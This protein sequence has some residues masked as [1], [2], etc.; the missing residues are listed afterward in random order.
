M[1]SE[2]TKKES[3]PGITP[4]TIDQ[5]EAL[6]GFIPLCEMVARKEM[7]NVAS[8]SADFK[9]FVNIGLIKVN[10]LLREAKEKGK[11]YN[12]SY[13]IQGISWEIKN[14]NR[15]EAHQRGE[16]RSTTYKQEYIDNG[17]TLAEIREA[18]L[19]TVVSLDDNVFEIA[20]EKSFN[21]AENVEANRHF[22]FCP[23][24]FRQSIVLHKSMATISTLVFLLTT[25]STNTALTDN[26]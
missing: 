18:V 4:T 24:L 19:E 5:K 26:P 7:K 23:T 2:S 22:M 15:Q 17:Y 21:P 13:V 12:A 25:I 9:E 14:K 10:T 16:F 1:E 20:D 6:I 8:H 3:F 11:T